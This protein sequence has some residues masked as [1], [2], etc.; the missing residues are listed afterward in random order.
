MAVKKMHYPV[1]I[2]IDPNLNRPKTAVARGT[3]Y[4]GG[5]K[6]VI[7]DERYISLFRKKNKLRRRVKKILICFGGSDPNDITLTVARLLK[8]QKYS[9]LKKIIVV[10]SGYHNYKQL[11]KELLGSKNTVIKKA[12]ADMASLMKDIDL[13]ILSGGVLMHEAAVLGIP[14]IVICHNQEQNIEAEAFHNHGIVYNLGLCNS[15]SAKKLASVLGKLLNS[16]S[17][18]KQLFNNARKFIDPY[19]TQR[20]VSIIKEKIEMTKA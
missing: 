4:Y 15:F 12:V 13:A 14:S 5:G 20:I 7:L 18:R 17:K 19:G 11:K 8:G 6:F 9:K 2:L 10:G 16:L 3:R 1:D